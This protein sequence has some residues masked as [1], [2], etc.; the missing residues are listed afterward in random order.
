MKKVKLY[1]EDLSCPDC[2]NKIGKVLNKLEGVDSADV[3]YTTSKANVEYDE[4][5]VSIAD[6]K[7]AVADTG[8]S[9]EQVM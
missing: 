4:D 2:A 8:Y 1:L 7:D 9:V 3:H 6:L 5:K